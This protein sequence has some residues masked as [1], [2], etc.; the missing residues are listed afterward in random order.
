MA[1]TTVAISRLPEQNPNPV[2]LLSAAEGRLTYA[3]AASAPI[4]N[5]WSVAVGDPVPPAVLAGLRAAADADPPASL[6]VRC[7]LRTFAV[8]AV[9]DEKHDA[10]A[11]YGTDITARKSIERFPDR[12]P[13]PVI[14]TDRAGMILYANS[15]SDRILRD[16]AVSV[17]DK[18]PADL[19]PRIWEACAGGGEVE[20]AGD[21]WTVAFRPSLVEEFDFV[22]LYGIDVTALKVIDRFPAANPNP[23]LRITRDGTLQY[24]NRASTGLVA[25]L[26]LR[27]GSPLPSELWSRVE[28]ALAA[29][30]PAPLEVTAGREIYELT[31][32]PVA[33]FDFVNLYGTDVTAA[34]LVEQANRENERLLLNILPASIAAR[35]R[36]GETVIA[37]KFDEITV[38]FADV[39]DFT[40]LSARMSASELVALLN[41]VFS[42]C[43]RLVD[44]YELE[45]I[46]TIGDAYMVVGGIGSGGSDHPERVASMALDMIDALGQMTTSGGFPLQ[47]RVGLHV[48]PA[49]AGV[50]GMK[51]FIYDVWG[52]T[53]NTASRL[54]STGEP[55]KIQVLKSTARRLAGSFRFE[56][57]G[58][59]D[60]KGKGSLETWFLVSRMATGDANALGLSA[61]ATGRREKNIA[62]DRRPST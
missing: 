51:K 1:R 53:V 48:G 29:H 58:E 19:L 61:E 26:D 55:G 27:I 41:E 38:L 43:D 17:G 21:R 35:L 18:L 4:R 42:I 24:A 44:R 15:A 34:R 52:D 50:I 45:K 47:I 12:N 7:E 62:R 5:A 11:A 56:R 2:M 23:V 30:D 54:E 36:G 57:R 33:E 22:N 37:D 31:V 39:V 25:A 60:L 10:I 13:N 40:P 49:V 14:R 32:V 28:S 20:V 46:K 6:E 59:V 3:N 16:L 8:L 9:W